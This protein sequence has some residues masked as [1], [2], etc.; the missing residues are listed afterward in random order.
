MN[1]TAHNARSIR[2]MT[3]MK[4]GDDMK[5]YVIGASPVPDWLENRLMPYLRYDGEMGVEFKG[6]I[7][8]FELQK[9]DVLVKNGN[10]IEVER[11]SNGQKNIESV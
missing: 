9:G 7:M 2:V 5:R 6:T 8:N 1:A 11:K 3:M 4:T 10:R